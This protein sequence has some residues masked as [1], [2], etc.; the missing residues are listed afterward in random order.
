MLEGL[1]STNWDHELVDITTNADALGAAGDSFGNIVFFR[2][3]DATLLAGLVS[4]VD[5][6][7]PAPGRL[8][9]AG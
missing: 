7:G 2:A 6:Y 9:L 4:L 8:M 3:E 5:S 1:G